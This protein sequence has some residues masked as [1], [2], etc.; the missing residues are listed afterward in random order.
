MSLYSGTFDSILILLIWQI[1]A[2]IN[3]IHHG[4]AIYDRY[5]P[6]QA[7]QSQYLPRTI[8]LVVAELLGLIHL[9]AILELDISI[10]LTR[11]EL[12]C[13]SRIVLVLASVVLIIE[14]LGPLLGLMLRSLSIE[15]VLTLGLGQLVDFSA[16]KACE[17][18]LCKLVRD[19]LACNAR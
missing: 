1:K 4:H 15:E 6:S 2:L 11:A 10:S 17:H 12:Q 18:L 14:V 5:G 7:V 8:D 9:V 13:N 19:W 3:A 16:G